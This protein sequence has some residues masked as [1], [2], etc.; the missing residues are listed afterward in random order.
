M[1]SARVSTRGPVTHKDLKSEK[2]FKK[3][4]P[5]P[6]KKGGTLILKTLDKCYKLKK[7]TKKGTPKF[8]KYK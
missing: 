1:P 6:T 8:Q 4:L 3:T 7:Q 5:P 2:F